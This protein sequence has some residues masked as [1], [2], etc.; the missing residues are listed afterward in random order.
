MNEYI[1]F[2]TNQSECTCHMHKYNRMHISYHT[3]W[4]HL[5]WCKCVRGQKVLVHSRGALQ[6]AIETLSYTLQ[7]FVGQ[8][9]GGGRRGGGGE[10][11]EE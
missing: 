11:R 9:E 7:P 6:L 3:Y 10:E 5:Q 4:A 1:D 2:E 8:T